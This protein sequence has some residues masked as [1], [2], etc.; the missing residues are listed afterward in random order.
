MCKFFPND[1]T[2]NSPPHYLLRGYTLNDS[3]D[4]WSIHSTLV[5]VNFSFLFVLCRYLNVFSYHN[6]E[7]NISRNTLSTKQV[8]SNRKKTQPLY[9]VGAKLY[10]SQKSHRMCAL[11]FKKKTLSNCHKF[12]QPIWQWNWM[13]KRRGIIE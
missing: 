6:V 13:E 2:V 8:T 9:F 3:K 12:V 7:G 11:S 1:I 5:Y 4:N 10:L